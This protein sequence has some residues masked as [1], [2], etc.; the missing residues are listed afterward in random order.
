MGHVERLTG[1]APSG[2]LIPRTLHET[3]IDAAPKYPSKHPR[4]VVTRVVFIGFSWIFN[5][6]DPWLPIP[7]SQS[8]AEQGARCFTLWEMRWF[9]CL[10]CLENR[11]V[12]H[13]SE[14]VGAHIPDL[15]F[16]RSEMVDRPS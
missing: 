7:S 6:Y 12:F 9:L 1:P 16:R 8:G 10:F 15:R 5:R 11:C 2:D 13:Y 4:T 14:L 3:R